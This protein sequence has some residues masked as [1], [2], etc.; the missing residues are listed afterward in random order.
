[1]KKILVLAGLLAALAVSSAVLPAL[2]D[3]D[4][5]PTVQSARLFRDGSV[6]CTGADDTS[7]RGGQVF[8]L[9]HPTKVYF[10]VR[11]RNAAPDT[12]YSLAVS[13]EP[14]CANPQFYPA[15]TTNADGKTT[16][17]GTYNTTAGEKNLLFNLVTTAT[18]GDPRNR[19]IATRNFRITVPAP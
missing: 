7:R 9:A 2:A 6:S 19:E 3:D 17:F 1:M 5:E 14:N 16:F 15:Q 12:P 10:T 13:E 11:L 18:I 4:D 8:A